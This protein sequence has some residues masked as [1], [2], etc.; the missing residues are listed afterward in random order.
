MQEIEKQLGR[1][2]TLAEIATYNLYKD[3]KDYKIIVGDNKIHY[4]RKI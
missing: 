3:N 1:K 2:L 4:L